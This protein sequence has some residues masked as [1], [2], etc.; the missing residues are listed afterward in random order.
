MMDSDG[1]TKIGRGDRSSK[2]GLS[3]SRFVFLDRRGFEQ[4]TISATDPLML[5]IL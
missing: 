4:L 1:G 3:L 2:N 5:V